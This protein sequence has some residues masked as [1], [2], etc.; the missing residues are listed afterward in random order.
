VASDLGENDY[1]LAGAER[2]A[3]SRLL[4]ERQMFAG[5][6]YLAGRSVESLLRAVIWRFDAEIKGG[7]QSLDTGHDLRELL[8]EIMDL[9]VLIDRA[10]RD[11]LFD[12]V[13]YV[14]RLWFNNMRFVP[15]KKL[16]E[17]WWRRGELDRNRDLK[18]AMRDFLRACTAIVRQCEALCKD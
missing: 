6:A 17:S 13:Q 3:E 15:T 12:N 11:E 4:L 8:R 9:G 10:G 18:L 14:A 1:R 16:R 5:A 2:L 7:R